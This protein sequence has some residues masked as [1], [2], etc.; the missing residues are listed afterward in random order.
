MEFVDINFDESF[1]IEFID[2]DDFEF[3]EETA[4]SKYKK[5][6]KKCKQKEAED[7]AKKALDTANGGPMITALKKMCA[8]QD[9]KEK[10]G[11]KKDKKCKK[12]DKKCKKC[13]GV[14]GVC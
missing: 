14:K 13:K 7:K 11:E 10:C 12:D 2:M 5:D 6:D 4:A 3:A 1:D 9:P 8:K